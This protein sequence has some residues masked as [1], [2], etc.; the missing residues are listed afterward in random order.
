MSEES[1]KKFALRSVIVFALFTLAA[2]SIV[3]IIRWTLVDD[4]D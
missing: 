1:W 3:A 2:G 4:I